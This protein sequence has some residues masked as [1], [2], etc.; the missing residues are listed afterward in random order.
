MGVEH[1]RL[2][3]DLDL[4]GRSVAGRSILSLVAR[5]DDVIAL[6]LHAVEMTIDGVSVNDRPT[7]R[8]DYDGQRLRIELSRAHKTGEQLTVAVSYRCTPRRGLYFFGPDE[9]NP[10]RPL[11]CWTQGQDE[12]SRHYWPG[13]DAPIEKATSEVVCTTPRGLTVLSNGELHERRDVEGNRTRWH[14]RLD[15]PHAGYLVTLVC[16]KSRR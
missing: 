1:V 16:G 15:F 6:T 9:N 5:R 12:D 7:K 14:Y 10:D 13:I 2:E 11:Q 3:L 4:A 8:F